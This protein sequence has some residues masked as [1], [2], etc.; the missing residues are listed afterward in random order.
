MSRILALD[1][2]LRT[3]GVAMSDPSKKFAFAKESLANDNSIFTLLPRLVLQEQIETIVIGRSSSIM[4]EEKAEQFAATL[5]K[6]VS[7]PIKFVDEMFTTKMAK[8][9]PH[10]LNMK[11]T[12]RQNFDDN[13]AAAAYILELYLEQNLESREQN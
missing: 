2:G 5:K 9:I 6:L 13:S 10:E 7:I 3:I 11:K 1:F 4:I 12:D 8:A